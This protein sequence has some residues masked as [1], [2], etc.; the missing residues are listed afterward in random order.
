MRPPS[1]TARIYLVNRPGA[2]KRFEPR[3]PE[4][5]E[6][7]RSIKV[8]TEFSGPEDLVFGNAGKP[9]DED[10]MRRRLGKAGKAAGIGWRVTWHCFR[11]YFASAADRFG[12]QTEDRKLAMGHAS[13]EM[14]A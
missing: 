2:G 11:R 9:M 5:I 6:V 13:E 14:T 8:Q 10:V 4:V 7:L 1:R 12:M 3:T